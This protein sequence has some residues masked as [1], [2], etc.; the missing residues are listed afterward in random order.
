MS[1]ERSLF[2]DIEGKSVEAFLL[3]NGSLRAR[4]ITY[5]AILSELH[6]PDRNGTVRDIVL[7]YDDL[8]S[9]LRYRGSAGA[10]CGRYANRIADA[11]FVIDG[12]TCQLSPNEPPNHLHGGFK[13]FSKRIW[14]AEPDSA[15][16]AVK[17]VLHRPHGDE[18]YPGSVS[19]GVTYRLSD[20]RTLDIEMEATTDRPTVVNLAYHGYWNL[21]GHGSGSVK[22]QLLQIDADHY[23]P[24]GPG[25]IPTGD[26]APV[27]GTAFDFRQE[28]PIGAAFDDRAQLPEGG[29]DHN[30]CLN[31][32]DGAL[33]RAARA[34][35]RVSGRALEI[36]TNQPGV[37]LYTANH[38]E[39]MPAVGKG[40]APYGKHAGFAL[41][42]QN[43]PNAPNVPHFPSAFLYPG[44]IYRHVMRIPLFLV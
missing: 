19:V 43:F 32:A 3:Q 24:V 35:D 33:R 20:E 44:E 37:Q 12:E 1:V 26:V 28:R 13:G 11:R 39:A 18:G 25:K 41:E 7:G 17:L 22:D 30:F 16:H 38:F 40:G 31:G 14:D 42:T 36:W 5:G 2:G 21:A 15:N 9:Y 27:A 10:I 4:V 8:A 6:V 34:F 29:Y 23:T